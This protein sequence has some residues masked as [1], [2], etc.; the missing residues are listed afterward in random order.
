[1]PYTLPGRAP[2]DGGIGAG[3]G[4]RRSPDL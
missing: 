3:A 2:P 1:V 4:A